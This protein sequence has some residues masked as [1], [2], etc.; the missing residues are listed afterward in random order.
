MHVAPEK[1]PQNTRLGRL[2]VFWGAC[3]LVVCGTAGAWAADDWES[4]VQAT[5]QRA[6]DNRGQLQQ[7]LEQVPADQRRGLRFLLAHM[8]ARDATELTSEFLLHNV[9]FAYRAWRGAS[10]HARVPEEIF[11]N[12]ILPYA[13]INEHRD[14]WRQTF[15][16]RFRP[17]VEDVDSPSRAAAILNQ[18][19]FPELK[20]RYSTQRKRAD[21]GP[22]QSMESGLASCTGLSILLIDACRAVGV[23]ARFVGTPLWSDGS[24]NHSWVEVWDDGWHFTGAAEPSGDELD[25]A[26]FV[27]RASAAQRDQRLNAIYAVSFRRTPITF[28]LVWDKSIDYVYAVNVTS[29]YANQV[30][31]TPEGKARV[32]LRVAQL[33]AGERVA[34]TFR[35]RDAAGQVAAEGTTNDE[36][37]DA[38]DHVSVLLDAGGKYE[39]EF[40]WRGTDL[41]QSLQVSRDGELFSFALPASE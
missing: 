23:P 8:P 15:Y 5:L 9:D 20:V 24:G 41:R 7:A 27:A 21:Q 2:W 4:D 12:E 6:G 31:P 14:N 34:A 35:V 18:K 38:N 28:P 29:R 19:I 32:L 30:P 17:L 39:V 16:E 37:F 25:R 36:R 10:W 33:P 13:N 40:R 26:W 3:V 1:R 22:F 11:L